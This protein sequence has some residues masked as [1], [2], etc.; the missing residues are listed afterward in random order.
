[1]DKDKHPG[2]PAIDPQAA[3]E[4]FVDLQT[5]GSFG[6]GDQ[7]IWRDIVGTARDEDPC[8]RFAYV[9]ERLIAEDR[10][11]ERTLQ[12]MREI[13]GR[14]FM[15]DGAHLYR[16]DARPEVDT[17]RLA[18]ARQDLDG[19]GAYTVASFDELVPRQRWMTDAQRRLAV[20]RYVD[21][22]T[23]QDDCLMPRHRSSPVTLFGAVPTP[24]LREFELPARGVLTGHLCHEPLMG[25]LAHLLALVAA[26]GAANYQ[27]AF[28]RAAGYLEVALRTPPI[29]A[30]NDEGGFHLIHI[31][32]D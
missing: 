30:M 2:T 19:V 25:D 24:K 4:R 32:A 3:A 17:K 11:R 15:K 27:D 31:C 6:S 9:A 23:G 21:V 13:R 12:L 7:E 20:R 14:C 26:I 5:R 1:M 18:A 10:F 22:A 28:Y 16:F 8:G 29:V